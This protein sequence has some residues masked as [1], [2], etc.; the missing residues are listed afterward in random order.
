MEDTVKCVTCTLGRLSTDYLSIKTCKII[1][2]LGRQEVVMSERSMGI[3][4]YVLEVLGLT[5]SIGGKRILKNINLNIRKGEVVLLL[6]PNASGKS[7]LVQSIIGNP[8]YKIEQGKILFF[9]ED[10]TNLPMEARVLKGIGLA[11]QLP[12]K[13]KGVKVRDLIIHMLRKR[14]ITTNI[15]DELEKYASLLRVQHLL[16]REINVGFSGGE[17]KRVELLFTL[18]QRPKLA[19][20]D[21]IDSGVDVENVALMGKV[22]N[23]HLVRNETSALIITHT[24][25]IAKHVKADRAYV[26]IDGTIRCEGDA[27]KIVETILQFGFERCIKCAR[28]GIW[29]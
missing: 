21:E 19:L 10:I 23:E 26:M 14:G 22:I 8:K 28:W 25:Q 17:M 11:Y 2:D 24:A 29:V 4:M 6:G 20:L 7:T 12:P 3:A 5:V 16:D 27:T 15:M 9:G 13:I 18:M 1:L